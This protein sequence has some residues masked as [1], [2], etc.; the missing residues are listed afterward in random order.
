M[1]KIAVLSGKVRSGKSTGLLRWSDNQSNAGGIIQLVEGNKRVLCDVAGKEKRLLEC[2]DGS[3]DDIVR[4]GFYS[5]KKSTFDWAK[6]VLRSAVE[7]K[8]SPI[9]IDEIGKLELKD[10]G[11]EP[12][13]TEVLERSKE[14]NY[15]VILVI[16]DFLLKDVLDKY[17]I[18]ADDFDHID[19]QELE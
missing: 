13:V 2:Q 3:P 16:R 4:V 7:E 8:K 18:S 9:I 15:T 17:G 11:L 12:A 6:N 1:K 14:S 19:L 5:F 10:G